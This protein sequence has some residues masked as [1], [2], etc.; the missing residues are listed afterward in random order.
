MSDLINK[1]T[2]EAKKAAGGGGKKP[3]HGGSPLGGVTGGHKTH[4]TRSKGGNSSVHKGMSST[5][6]S[7]VPQH[8]CYYSHFLLTTRCHLGIDKA[9]DAV[10]MGDKYDSKLNK[11]ADS[12]MKK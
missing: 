2:K 1:A 10:G 6:E 9:T 3:G 7:L 12:R 4:N 11:L 5:I 8:S